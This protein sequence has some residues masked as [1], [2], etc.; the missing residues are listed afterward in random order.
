[1]IPWTGYAIGIL[2]AYIL[3]L[4]WKQMK[5][6]GIET[7]IQNV[8]IAFYIILTNFP[9]PEAE[10]AILPLFSVAIFTSIPLYIVF[11]GYKAY[12]YIYKSETNIFTEVLENNNTV[13]YVM[14]VQSDEQKDST[15]PNY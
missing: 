8:G 2:A 12:K 6:I 13:N 7:G 5:T 10:I 9:S 11:V 1:M 4:E 14:V 3:R 15:E